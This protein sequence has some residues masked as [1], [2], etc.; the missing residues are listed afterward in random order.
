MRAVTV[1]PDARLAD[2]AGGPVGWR[3]AARVERP[4]TADALTWARTSFEGAPSS[5]RAL[6]VVGWRTLLLVGGPRSD[7]THVLGWPIVR[8]TPGAAVLQRRSRL[9][10]HATLLFATEPDAVTFS[11]AM[12]FTGRPGRMVWA[13][14]APVHRWVV[15]LVLG[16]AST[17]IARRSSRA[18]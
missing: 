3:H 5:L 13:V 7:A 15:R 18:S 6:L 17:V 9:G 14:V 1:D 10:I 8:T 2:L 4:P 12:V 16:H 11:S